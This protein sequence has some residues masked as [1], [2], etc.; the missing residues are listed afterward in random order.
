MNKA[1][2][3][4]TDADGA[5]HI[6]RRANVEKKSFRN[7]FYLSVDGERYDPG[8]GVVCEVHQGLATFV[9]DSHREKYLP[10]SIYHGG[11][12]QTAAIH[13]R[14]LDEADLD[15][16]GTVTPADWLKAGEEKVNNWKLQYSGDSLTTKC[17]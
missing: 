2:A 7:K 9:C 16:E 15:K 10:T 11:I 12:S 6:P 13:R 5:H 17:G 4:I 3:P 8:H 14:E 1:A